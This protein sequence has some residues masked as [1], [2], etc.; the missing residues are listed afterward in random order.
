MF[1]INSNYTPS[2]PFLQPEIEEIPVF[3]L[4]FPRMC[5]FLTFFQS[6]LRVFRRAGGARRDNGCAIKEK[7]GARTMRTPANG[8][9]RTFRFIF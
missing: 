9:E 5:G 2:K 8:K 7:A 6:F 3:F 4:Y 1:Q